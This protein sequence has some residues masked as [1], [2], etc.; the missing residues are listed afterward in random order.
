VSGCHIGDCHYI[1]ANHWTEKRVERVRK[2]MAKRGIRPERLQLEWVSAAEGIR[3]AALMQ[4][5]E[6]LR[7]GVSTK[8]IADTME[9]L[10]R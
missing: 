1:D 9:R 7:R 2:K 6:E 10:A 3:F 5:M 8:E 4:R